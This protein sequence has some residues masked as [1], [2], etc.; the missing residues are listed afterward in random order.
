MNE[1]L[2]IVCTVALCL[3][4]IALAT[5]LVAWFVGLVR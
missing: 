3:G 2:F 1:L 5:G 4:W